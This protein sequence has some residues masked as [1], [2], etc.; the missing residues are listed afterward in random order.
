VGRYTVISEAEIE[1]VRDLYTDKEISVKE[2]ERLTGIPAQRIYRVAVVA[3]LSRTGRSTQGASNK[4]G[5]R[6]GLPIQDLRTWRCPGKNSYCGRSLHVEPVFNERG[7]STGL[8]DLVCSVHHRFIMR[9][10]DWG[11]IFKKG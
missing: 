5:P 10:E 9:E 3:G 2:I 1:A 7:H 8:W 4:E 6:P 11:K